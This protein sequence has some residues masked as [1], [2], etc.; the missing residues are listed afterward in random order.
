MKFVSFDESMEALEKAYEKPSLKEKIFLSDGVD[1]VLASDI[2]ATFNSPSYP[3]SAMDGYAIKFIDQ[4]MGKIKILGDNPAGSDNKAEVIG[5]V[6]IKTFTGSLIPKGAD[7]L[8][9]IELVEVEDNHIIIKEEVS[10]GKN[11]REIGENFKEGEVLIKKGTKLNFADIGVIAS[12]NIS[13]IEVFTKPILGV[14]S[15]GSEILDVGEEQTNDAQIRSSNQFVIESLA[16]KEGAEVVRHSLIKDDKEAIK[17]AMQNLLTRC[18]IV[19]TTGGVSVGDYDFVKLILEDFEPEYITK[20]VSLKPGQHIKIVKLGKKFIV[21]L[22][23]FPY[24]S[25]VTFI[26]YVIPLI[27]KLM[28][29]NGELKYKS[30]TLKNNFKKKTHKTEFHAG[31]LSLEN[32]EYFVDFSCKKSG[33]SAILTN[34]LGDVA[35]ARVDIEQ[36]ELKKGDKIK[37]LDMENF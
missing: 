22:P 21:A 5:G 37:I 35:L 15:T 1:R 27:R 3:T 31:S 11:V 7:S 12:L 2:V 6:C 30:A 14:L 17:E 25:T 9:P 10:F 4:A 20:G 24:S 36:K 18:D 33:T 28:G 29:L 32:G 23:G 8:I 26:L 16:K 34:M 13:Q 19:V